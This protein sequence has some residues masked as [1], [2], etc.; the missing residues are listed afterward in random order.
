M[1]L[2]ERGYH[3]VSSFFYSIWD[4]LYRG[5]L[6]K[7]SKEERIVTAEYKMLLNL[8]KRAYEQ[9]DPKK[10]IFLLLKSLEFNRNDV[11]N[12]FKSDATFASQNDAYQTL[13]LIG[14]SAMQQY[15]DAGLSDLGMYDMAWRN[16]DRVADCNFHPRFQ[17]EANL[18][19]ARLSLIVGEDE[20]AT[21]YLDNAIR[22][23]QSLNISDGGLEKKVRELQSDLS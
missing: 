6:P 23:M 2:F 11:S 22:I 16:F 14:Q 1:N 21:D 20:E 3:F 9:G 13:L 17:V 19:L 8:G 10:A 15:F 4:R 5:P 18:G 12:L 7:P